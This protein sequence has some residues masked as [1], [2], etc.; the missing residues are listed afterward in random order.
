MVAPDFT[1]I[2]PARLNSSRLPNKPLLPLLG[3]PMI[4]H[5]V[6]RALQSAAS[7]VL[8]ATDSSKIETVCKESGVE[9]VMTSSDHLS[10]T[11]RVA[12]VVTTLE[13][14]PEQ[15]VVNVQ[16]DEPLIP[17]EVINQ[18]AQN[19]YL[20][21]EIGICTLYAQIN[22]IDEWKNPNVVKLI[23][24][25]EG[26]VLYFSR[27]PIPFIRDGDY[28]AEQAIAKRHVGL[29]AYR[30]EILKNFITWPVPPIE[31]AEKL[32][33]LRAMSQGVSIHAEHANV[34]IPAGVDTPEDFAYVEAFLKEKYS[35]V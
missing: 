14:K 30:V 13:L 25:S 31:S 5:V 10:G 34:E 3:K 26:K 23:T 29:Y 27:A 20:R 22:S 17:K 16:G 15:I 9:V 12:E 19:L 6:E 2:I 28:S 33:Q 7:R 1:V 32:E 24:D 8:V 21:R 4:L 35:K 11:D 18:V